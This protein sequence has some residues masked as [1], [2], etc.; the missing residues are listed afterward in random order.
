MLKSD[1]IKVSDKIKKSENALRQT[2]RKTWPDKCGMQQS[3]KRKAHSDTSLS[4]RNEKISN[5]LTYHLKEL[6]R[7]TTTK[8]IKVNRKKAAIKITGEINKT[9]TKK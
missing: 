1:A 9:E 7:T 4:S 3:L 6:K 5:K 2:T 8:K